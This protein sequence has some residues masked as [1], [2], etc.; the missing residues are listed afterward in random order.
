MLVGKDFPSRLI[1]ALISIVF[2]ILTF[3]P[4]KVVILFKICA[5]DAALVT[6]NVVT[7]TLPPLPD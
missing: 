5:N 3:V 7:F 2:A 4:A 1:V 6:L